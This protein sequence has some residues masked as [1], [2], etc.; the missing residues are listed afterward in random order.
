MMPKLRNTERS[1]PDQVVQ[2]QHKYDVQTILSPDAIKHL[3][4]GDQAVCACCG[5]AIVFG[6]HKVRVNYAWKKRKN[7]KMLYYCSYSCMR[8]SK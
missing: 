2:K 3:N 1:V 7:G 8:A 4:L 5:K 6:I